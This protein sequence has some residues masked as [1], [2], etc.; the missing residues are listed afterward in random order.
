MTRD[1]RGQRFGM[2]TAVEAV[3]RQNKKVVWR[4]ICDCGQEIL[5]RSDKLKEKEQ[6]TRHLD[7]YPNGKF[8]PERPRTNSYVAISKYMT[9]AKRR[10]IEWLLTYEQAMILLEGDCFFCGAKPSI[11][12]AS[13][14]GVEFVRNGIDRLNPAQDYKV[15][16]CVTCCTTCNAMKG[17]MT[18]DTFISVVSRIYAHIQSKK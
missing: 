1:F 3:G 9:G 6:S 13:T 2:V 7:H 18:L 10:G 12:E 16:N 17:V 8:M 11:V 4:C 14:N 5:V 15:E